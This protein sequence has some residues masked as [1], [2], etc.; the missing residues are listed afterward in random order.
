VV[1]EDCE[2]TPAETDGVA[3]CQGKVCVLI[4]PTG[5]DDCNMLASDGCEA[6]LADDIAHCG[7]CDA[8]CAPE[9]AAGA[10]CTS[11]TDG[12]NIDK[13]VGND[14]CLGSF[15]DCNNDPS[16][17]CE[18]DISV[19][20]D[21]CGMCD[22][23]CSD[24]NGTPTCDA[25]IC[26][27]NCD[28]GFADC[29][30]DISASCE[31]DTNLS[32]ARCGGCLAGDN[33]SGSGEACTAS[34]PTKSPF[35]DGG[36]C[37]EVD[38]PPGFGD[39]DGSA[40]GNSDCDDS[41]DTVSDCGLCGEA[42][43]VANGSPTCLDPGSGF[44]CGV[45]TCESVGGEVWANCDGDAVSGCDVEMQSNDASCGGCL[46]GE[47]GE[48]TFGT[49]Q[50]CTQILS[51]LTKNVTDV[52]CTTGACEILGCAAGFADCDGDFSNGC[53]VNTASDDNH[54]NGCTSGPTTTWDGGFI[55]DN[56]YT[57]GSGSCSNSVCSFDACDA[58]YG[59]CTGGSGDADL[60][61]S[62]DGCEEYLVGNDS[63][64]NACFNECETDAQTSGN[65]CTASA[66]RACSPVCSSASFDSCDSNGANGCE[67][68]LTVASSCGDCDTDCTLSVGTDDITST[69]CNGEQE[70]K[71]AGCGAGTDD[72]NNTFSDGCES[73]LSDAD[74]CGDCNTDCTTSEGTDNISTTSCVSNQCK[75]ATCD[76]A[77]RG[78]CNTVFGDGCEV[79]TN[80]NATHCGGCNAV[81][82]QD[83]TASEGS[84]NIST[85]NCASGACKVATCNSASRAD[86]NGTFSDGCEIN[87]N[88]NATHCGACNTQ[89]G[90]NCTASEGSNNISTT[91]CASGACKVA[92]CAANRGDC[93]N[94]FSDGCETS[95][96]FNDTHC[97]GC[98]T[99][100]GQNCASL[101]TYYECQSGS[102]VPGPCQ[103]VP[104]YNGSTNYNA[105]T[106][107]VYNN[108]L[109]ES[110]Y[111]TTGST[112][113]DQADCQWQNWC[114][115]SS[116]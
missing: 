37:D 61:L 66:G 9:N 4:C 47:P 89:G 18:A 107:V 102:C 87:T 24:L 28:A 29:D 98:N 95:T 10:D 50:D 3:S 55:C 112:P 110:N 60:G 72:C 42:C 93:N 54:C 68:S 8:L 27:E 100:G 46:A 82:G 116:C 74:T 39:C 57:H 115:V 43:S 81:D 103:G 45:D 84:N 106:R 70:C 114:R 85:T 92:T 77:S 2:E 20:A 11:A 17:G 97:G 1:A 12:C 64:C 7:A 113:V 52:S 15:R 51:D 32:S 33:N 104:T 62:G 41:L 79:N 96:S 31:V 105:G 14:G 30:A 76:S 25:G 53:E 83:C 58:D 67:A 44:V 80:T 6:N 23:A 49:G 108:Q 94:T 59:D 75:V 48:G 86:C 91:S 13:A 40:D 78:D 56:L 5:T 69:T 36:T 101:G 71:V 73:S 65:S 111:N 26:V 21:H 38:C 16:D 88:T 34:G 35:C 22:S 19:N 90:V 99:K 109:W 63:H